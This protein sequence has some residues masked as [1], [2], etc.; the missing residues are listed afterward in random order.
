[1]RRL[2]RISTLALVLCMGFSFVVMAEEQDDYRDSADNV[3]RAGESVTVE[4]EE[5]RDIFVA[6]SDVLIE[7]IYGAE[8]VFAAGK[9]IELNGMEEAGGDV[10]AAGE[11]IEVSDVYA[12]GN[13]FAACESLDISDDS[14]FSALYAAGSNLDI[15]GTYT[16]LYVAGSNVVF[17]GSI[18][19]SGTIEADNVVITEDARIN[20]KLLIKS[21][22]EPEIES[23]EFLD[24]IVYEQTKSDNEIAETAVKASIFV[25]IWNK[26]RKV[27]FWIPASVIIGLVLCLAIQ[28]HLDDAG[29]MIKNRT[30]PMIVSGIIAY[31][32]IP[33]AI[34][35]LCCT[36]IGLPL[37]GILTLIYVILLC[38]GVSFTGASLS[39]LVFPKLHP[40]L[41]AAIGIAVIQL[42]KMI[43]FIGWLVG[44]AC[45]MYLLGYTVQ[46]VYIDKKNESQNRISG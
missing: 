21:A 39:R 9:Y 31:I 33:V 1:M 4:N 28:R 6:G 23:S 32:S 15:G 34:V 30:S 45:D 42:V 5:C 40:M 37:A 8:S 7:D 10:F 25:R 29:T 17:S 27:L 36:V 26:V 44:V 22:N 43:P 11:K 12:D 35:I 46:R 18:D 14:S 16:A 20:G 13:M 38:L 19:G 24:N 3:F 41:A 2:M